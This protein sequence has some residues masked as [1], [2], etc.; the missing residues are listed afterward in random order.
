MPYRLL[1]FKVRA[2]FGGALD[3]LVNNVGMSLRKG[4][5]DYS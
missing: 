2:E 3:I 5:T 1:F 4:T